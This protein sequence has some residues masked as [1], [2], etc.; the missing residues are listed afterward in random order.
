MVAHP[1]DEL[2]FV[3]NVGFRLATGAMASPNVVVEQAGRTLTAG[4]T[5]DRDGAEIRMTVS[6]IDEVLDFRQSRVVH[7]PVRVTDDR[8]RVM[9]E[10]SQRYH[11]NS[12][13]Y[14]LME[15]PTRFQR[16]VALDRIEPDARAIEIVMTGGA[17]DWRFTI[18]IERQSASGA[19][20]RPTAAID[21]HQG[22]AIEAPLVARSES[23]TAIE[24][25]AYFVD[26]SDAAEGI[27]RTI[28]GIGCLSHTRGLGQDL[29]MLRDS[30]GRH[31]LE[32][33]RGIQ[34]SAGRGRRREVAI[35]EPMPADAVSASF[36]IP[37]VVIC[38]MSDETVL[39]P[40]PAESEVT[41]AG[42]RAHVTTTRVSRS[43]DSTAEHPSPIE[44]LNG[45][46]VRIV[47]TPSDSDAERQLVSCG[48]MESNDRGMTVS[49]VRSGPPVIEVPDPSDD[50]AH[51][52]FR[53]PRIRV[54][55]PWKLEVPLPSA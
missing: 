25:Q 16:M 36:E 26:D 22:I 33:A 1:T 12:H 27:K 6:G 50:S 42:C 55:G 18:P 14:R 21:V 46:R 11:V 31:H 5:S 43:S 19:R 24:L 34:D 3:P 9:E 41:L 15:G 23:I 7:A 32:H 44:G 49:M 4:V 54:A 2:V 45:P 20:A 10:R 30:T 29:L 39:V 8:G 13:L 53:G 38:E 17:G 48:V 28:E 47:I 52:T 40:V 35:F 51:V 37:Y